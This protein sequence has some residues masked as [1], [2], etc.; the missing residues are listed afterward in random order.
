MAKK[1]TKPAGTQRAAS[2][3]DKIIGSRVRERRL[4][5]DMS[6]ERLAELLGITFQQVQKYE[7]GINRISASRLY[8]VAGALNVQVSYFYAGLLTSGEIGPLDPDREEAAPVTKEGIELMKLF[9]PLPKKLK[10][11]ILALVKALVSEQD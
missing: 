2:K 10:Q 9:N 6:Q 7:K 4:E 11:R 5:I 3:N 1:P 8:D